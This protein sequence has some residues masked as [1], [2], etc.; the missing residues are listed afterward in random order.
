[1]GS[2]HSYTAELE[3]KDAKEF[4]AA[5]GRRTLWIKRRAI[6]RLQRRYVPLYRMPRLGSHAAIQFMA[7]AFPKS[8]LD[9]EG[10]SW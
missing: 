6:N 2:P 3:V 5:F 8:R 7:G 9:T 1:M 10:A 4:Y